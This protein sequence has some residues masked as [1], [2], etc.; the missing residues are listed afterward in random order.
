M[1]SI[2]FS[3]LSSGLDTSS[4]ID[5]LVKVD[6]ER[7]KPI[8]ES[9]DK[10]T[11]ELSAE[12]R[13]KSYLSAFDGATKDISQVSSFYLSTVSS[14]N[15]SILTATSTGKADLGQG[16]IDVEVKHLAVNEK[17]QSNSYADKKSDLTINGDFSINGKNVSIVG[18]DSLEEIRDKINGTDNVGVVASILQVS[19]GDYRLTLSNDDGGTEGAVLGDGNGALQ[20][21]GITT[22]AQ[23]IDSTSIGYDSETTDL[24]IAGDFTI[25][26]E[27]VTVTA[28]DSLQDISDKLGAVSGVTSGISNVDGK[29]Q[30]DLSGV[31]TLD[32]DSK[33]VLGRMGL[34]TMSKNIL[35][36]GDDAEIVVDGSITVKRQSNSID[37]VIQGLNINLNKAEV[38]TTV[39]IGF[40]R[41]YDAIADKVQ[42]FINSYNT[43]VNYIGDQSK[44]DADTNVAG[45][46]A[47]SRVAK[48][49]ISDLRNIIN[50]DHSAYLP[51][52]YGTLANIGITTDKTKGILNTDST[53][54]KDAMKSNF[55]AFVKMFADAKSTSI[56]DLNIGTSTED[57]KSGKYYSDPLNHTFYDITEAKDS[58]DALPG[59]LDSSNSGDKYFLTTDKKMYTWD[60]SAWDGGVAVTSANVEFLNGIN[61]VKDGNGKGIGFDGST[62]GVITFTKGIS[63]LFDNL[64]NHN[65]LDSVDGY[66]TSDDKRIHDTI[67]SYD[68]QYTKLEDR[69]TAYRKRLVNQFAQVE[70]L[71]TKMK[72]QS[73]GLSSAPPIQTPSA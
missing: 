33:N 48:R 29:Y 14:N 62:S 56:S 46:L 9:A 40:A 1:G 2:Q 53:K 68:K 25:N 45:D 55:D 50:T 65:M 39:T 32:D 66:F 22:N 15:D 58:T 5:S 18:S 8:A 27:V 31:S 47:N 35:Q 30:I 44:Y 42:G 28:S 10:L 7:L 72:M 54:L 49:T 16:S 6:S 69:L 34:T 64:V 38:G 59:T 37:D 73:S 51:D 20:S 24:N 41:D 71:M 43:V 63:G 36:S 19:D 4:I 52:G 61:T 21:L 13:L 23:S 60:G 11:K 12:G 3:G 57:T 67:D 26:G 70:M 17:T